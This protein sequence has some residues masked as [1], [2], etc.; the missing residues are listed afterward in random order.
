M[1]FE[2]CFDFDYLFNLSFDDAPGSLQRLVHFF[3]ILAAGLGHVR[4]SA[5]ATAAE[6]RYFL[7]DLAAV[8]AFGPGYFSA[9]YLLNT[10]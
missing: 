5:A 3:R 7:H 10:S 4:T 9:R 2:I 6:G 1:Y 8:D